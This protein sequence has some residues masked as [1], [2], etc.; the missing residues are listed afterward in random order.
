MPPFHLRIRLFV[1]AILACCCLT[2]LGQISPEAVKD[3]SR[4][5]SREQIKSTPGSCLSLSQAALRPNPLLV[6]GFEGQSNR[7][8]VRDPNLSSSGH[9]RTFMNNREQEPLPAGR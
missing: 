3:R 7:M 8:P 4:E 5:Q 2:C 1:I 9:H 6:R